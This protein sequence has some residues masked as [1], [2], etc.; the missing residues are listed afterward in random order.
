MRR[1]ADMIRD[2]G[3]E[4]DPEFWPADNAAD[5]SQSYAGC[6]DSPVAK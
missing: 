2:N 3:F 5:C 1:T 4:T 6:G